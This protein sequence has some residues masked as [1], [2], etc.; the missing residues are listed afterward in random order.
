VQLTLTR[1]ELFDLVWSTSRQ[2]ISAQYPDLSAAVITRTCEEANVPLPG[3]GYWAKLAEG[4]K[5]SRPSLP[6]RWPGQDELVVLGRRHGYGAVVDRR[7]DEE[8]AASEPPPA[9]V[10][11]DDLNELVEVASKQLPLVKVARDL[12]AAHPAVLK[13]LRREEQRR[14]K[15]SAST[16]HWDP[17]RYEGPFFKRQLRILD[18]IFRGMTPIA[19]K[20][21]VGEESN[22]QQ[23]VG[24]GYSLSAS[25]ELGTTSVHLAFPLDRVVLPKDSG[26]YS[27]K[28]LKLE[29]KSWAGGRSA[30]LEWQDGPEGALEKQLPEITRSLLRQ[31][32]LQRRA[33]LQ[34]RHDWEVQRIQEA[35]RRLEAASEKRVV[36]RREALLKQ[37]E[38][39]AHASSLRRFAD[40]CESIGRAPGD[41]PLAEWLAFARD[42]ASQLDPSA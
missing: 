41:E 37:A 40:H 15:A 34:R 4:H 10:F 11:D 19:R 32:E 27:Q 21:S 31:A 18:A 17:P 36:Q 7:S 13:I 8:I 35:A 38:A 16:W 28:E 22:F 6:R 5:V 3:R 20:A 24:T 33:N 39:F 14:V 30:G 26:A 2:A 1:Q 29:L 42:L 25:I 9:P 23:G 12:D